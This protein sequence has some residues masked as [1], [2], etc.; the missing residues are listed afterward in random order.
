VRIFSDKRFAQKIPRTT[1]C[2]RYFFLGLFPHGC[3]TI[4]VRLLVSFFS[5]LFLSVLLRFYLL[6]SR[7]ETHRCTP[8]LGTVRDGVMI[9]HALP[10]LCHALD[11]F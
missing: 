9:R 7:F 1:P 11:Y 10:G 4:C 6:F 8:D 2:F 3:E 5:G